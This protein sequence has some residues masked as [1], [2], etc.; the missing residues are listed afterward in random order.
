MPTTKNAPRTLDAWL[1]ELDGVRLPVDSTQ[2]ERVRRAMLDNRRSLRDIADLI[3]NSPTIALGLLRAANRSSNS[4][5]EPSESLEVALNR[6][7]L[8][9]AE[10]IV[11]QMP[12]LGNEPPPQALAQLQLISHHASQQASGLFASRLAR[13]WQEI[14]WNSLLFLAPFWP[15]VYAYPHYFEQWE[16]RVLGDGES[17]RRVE[18]ELLGVS[19]I[20]LG[21]TV[22]QRWRLPEWIVQGYRLLGHDRRL[23]VQALHIAHD[24]EHPLHQQQ[25]LD[26]DPNLRRWLTQPANSILL[27]NGLA[28]SSHQNWSA[29]HTLRWQQ[30][31]G[32]YLQVPLGEVQ[33]LIHQ[34]AV[35]S[36]RQHS[37]TGL[38]HPALALIWPWSDCRL[39]SKQPPKPA[40]T[41][42][43]VWKEQ[44]T[45]LLATPSPF[46]NVLQ[47]T[48]CARLALEAGGMSRT[49]ILLADRSQ[50]RL[51][52]QQAVGLVKEAAQLRL[53]PAT[54]QVLKHL[55]SKPGQLRLTPANIAKFSALL[56]GS[57][58][59]LFP[60]E[61]LLLRSIASNERVVML[62]V[63]DQG[64]LEISDNVFQAFGKTAQCIERAL[65]TFARKT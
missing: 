21:L 35:S 33:Q 22:A 63:A 27:A 15:L 24:N 2:Q 16:R 45:R 43:N 29:P 58:K 53:D 20:Q 47:L 61:H 10:S 8:K 56:P 38:W 18:R 54:S 42:P 9:R 49:L 7:G 37:V 55:L 39:R 26:A 28:I 13:L 36:A 17:A 48:E 65:A 57:L 62:I 52:A 31:T 19:V 25:M 51:M 40:K 32:L 3:Q 64:G 59:A 23:L 4:L 12:P 14:H 41:E 5:S 1:K 44:C 30:L 34:H 46:S 11:S 6:L 60:S 50:S